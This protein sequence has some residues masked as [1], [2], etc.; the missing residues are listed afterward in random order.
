MKESEIRASAS[1]TGE[2]SELEANL[3]KMDLSDEKTSKGYTD[4][5]CITESPEARQMSSVGKKME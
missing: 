4:E 5:S 1:S 3:E 2:T